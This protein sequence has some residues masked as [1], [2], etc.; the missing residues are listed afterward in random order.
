MPVMNGYEATRA[1]RALPDRRLASIPVTALSAN[2]LDEDVKQAMAAGM[3][4]HIAKPLDVA[5]LSKTLAKLIE[6]SRVP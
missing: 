6:G 2:A 4:A 3:N 1:I 5:V